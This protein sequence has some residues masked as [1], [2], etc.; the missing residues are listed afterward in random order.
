MCLILQSLCNWKR[1]SISSE[2]FCS[3]T[4]SPLHYEKT[5]KHGHGEACGW[6]FNRNLVIC[7]DTVSEVLFCC[8]RRWWKP[9]NRLDVSSENLIRKQQFQMTSTMFSYFAVSIQ[10]GKPFGISKTFSHMVAVSF[11][12]SYFLIHFSYT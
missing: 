9:T 5:Q 3:Q 10:T 8:T 12:Y 4:V 7:E 6:A 1:E 2:L 11:S